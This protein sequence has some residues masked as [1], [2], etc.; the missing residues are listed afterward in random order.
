MSERKLLSCQALSRCLITLKV[1]MHEPLNVLRGAQERI[2]Q[3]YCVIDHRSP[4]IG[5]IL[6]LETIEDAGRSK[7]AS[8]SLSYTMKINSSPCV[9][10]IPQS[11]VLRCAVPLCLTLSAA[12]GKI[13]I[14][15]GSRQ[16]TR[17]PHRGLL[18]A[19]GYEHLS[20]PRQSALVLHMSP[21]SGLLHDANEPQKT[22]PSSLLTP[23]CGNPRLLQAD[24]CDSVHCGGTA[25]PV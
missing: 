15:S 16:D 13:P 18:L 19:I 3:E 7:I 2:V 20:F 17:F 10:Q 21:S 25:G 14:C 6:Q 12:P 23:Q 8:S 24:N 4:I 5:R 11:Q 22:V 1:P 9:A